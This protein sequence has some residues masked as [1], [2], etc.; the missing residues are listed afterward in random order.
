MDLSSQSVARILY[1][2][3]ET[4]KNIKSL[5][6]EDGDSGIE[7]FNERLGMKDSDG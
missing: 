2:D 6:W 7:I 5:E 1:L 3:V 4:T